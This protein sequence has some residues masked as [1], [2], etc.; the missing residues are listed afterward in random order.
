ERA[1]LEPAREQLAVWFR[2]RVITSDVRSP[3]RY[4]RH[5]DVQPRTDLRFQRGERI[6]DVTGPR[7]R[8]EALHSG[9]TRPAQQERA[10]V[11]SILRFAFRECAIAHQVVTIVQGCGRRALAAVEPPAFDSVADEVA[12]L[13]P[14][15]CARGRLR[16]VD[17]PLSIH[18]G[19]RRSFRVGYL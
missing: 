14:P 2:R 18:I 1:E 16:K 11:R 6:V 3:I 13:R 10:P 5:G 15:P 4:P 7:S 19:D 9:A 8:A 12:M 17:E